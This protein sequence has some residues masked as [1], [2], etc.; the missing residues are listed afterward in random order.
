MISGREPTL[1]TRQLLVLATTFLPAFCWAVE[2]QNE[3][4][5][6]WA[7]GP[8]ENPSNVWTE[9]SGSPQPPPESS[10]PPPHEG[11][12]PDAQTAR[13]PNNEE[14]FDPHSRDWSVEADESEQVDDE[15][16]LRHHIVP[17]YSFWFGPALAWSKPFGDLWGRC[18]NFDA[19]GRCASIQNVSVSDR[20]GSGPAFELDAGARLGRHYNV[21]AL[22]ERTWFSRGSQSESNGVRQNGGDSDFVAL[23]LRVSTLP[24]KVGFVLDIAVGTRRMRAQWED[25]TELQLTDAPFE[26]RLGIGADVRLDENWSITSLL[27]LGLGSFGKAEWVLPDNSIRAASE[28][29][30]VALTHGWVGLQVS[31]HADIFG[32]KE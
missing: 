19:Y 24:E 28:P 10:P 9:P 4:S 12:A 13:E 30:D 29:G 22:W 1:L 32:S 5:N 17:R 31:A 23:G 26:T 3:P 8:S 2:A 25:G 20:F 11:A 27:H 14:W 15:A 16:T 7:A 21:Y 18:G 6:S